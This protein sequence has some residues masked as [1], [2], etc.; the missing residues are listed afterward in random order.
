MVQAKALPIMLDIDFTVSMMDCLPLCIISSNKKLRNWV[1]QNFMLPV[2]CIEPDETLEYI[3]TDGVKYG[4]NYRN[5]QTILRHSFVCGHIMRDVKNIVDLIIDRINRD[6]YSV[7]FLDNY[8]IKGSAAY[9]EWHYL[10]EVLVYGY[11]IAKSHFDAVMYTQRM[12]RVTILFEDF[13]KGFQGIFTIPKYKEGGWDEYT[14]MLYQ[15]IKHTEDYPFVQEEFIGKVKTYAKG[16]IQDKD[17]FENLLYMRCNKQKCFWGIKANEAM[18][19]K[20]ESDKTVF[21]NTI[22]GQ[23]KYALFK[24]YA[25]LHTY[26]EFHRGFLKRLKYA[27]EYQNLHEIDY[28]KLTEYEIIVKECEEIRLLYLK[29]IE[30]SNRKD[31]NRIIKTIDSVIRKLEV[32]NR[33]EV[34]ILCSLVAEKI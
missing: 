10:H 13:L 1:K 12:C 7:I 25:A 2:A 6:W 31:D 24:S 21:L 26:S 33:T 32:V 23:E 16:I 11:D 22:V 8:Y 9:H 17:Y 27:V 19:L 20:M 34:K 28:G 18:L 4:A 15:L 3:I 29:L 14:L 30:F 5:P